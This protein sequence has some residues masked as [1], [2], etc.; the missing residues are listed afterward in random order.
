MKMKK[1]TILSFAAA[2]LIVGGIVTTFATSSQASGMFPSLDD[3]QES[4]F[5]AP[6]MQAYGKG[7]N[8]YYLSRRYVLMRNDLGG[9]YI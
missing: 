8:Y 5:V 9:R 6:N 2:C 7:D 4:S 3:Q 1:A